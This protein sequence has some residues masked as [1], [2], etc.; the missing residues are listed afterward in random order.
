MLSAVV[1]LPLLLISESLLEDEEADLEEAKDLESL[2]IYFHYK[3]EI[4]IN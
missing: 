4:Y 3:N 1:P 2:V